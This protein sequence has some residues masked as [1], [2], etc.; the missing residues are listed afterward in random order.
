MSSELLIAILGI[1]IVAA[2][3]LLRAFSHGRIEVKL[4]DAVIA[5]LPLVLWLVVSGKIAKLAIGPDTIT[6]ETAREAIVRA[7]DSAIDA[8]VTS[9]PV[10]DLEI[11][12]KGG[13]G[14]ILGLVAQGVQAL[15]FTLGYG[16][17]VG[18]AIE[19]YLRILNAQAFFRYVV[20]SNSGGS[21][22][23]M[24]DPR[25]L[26]A[27]VEAEGPQ[28]WEDFAAD[29]NAGDT[30]RLLAL[31]EFVPAER[32]ITSSLSK[33]EA[34]SR[35]EMEK[36]DWLPVVGED[37]RFVGIVDRAGVTAGLVLD[38]ANQLEQSPE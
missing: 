22:F 34:L 29:L 19:E 8:Q 21:L 20:F 27:F 28:G 11:A 5:C 12:A 31:P 25:K 23:G 32:A 3:V 6:I 9:L 1:V 16:G 14:E 38:V 2:L 15:G 36:V 33:R 4:T 37:S 10:Q 17:Y 7:S 13:T 24:I 30:T 35:M 18:G 26:A